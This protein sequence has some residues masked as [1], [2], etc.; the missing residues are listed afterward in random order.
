MIHTLRYVIAE[1][2]DPYQNIADEA[3]LLE[4]VKEGE[5]ILFL[6]Q[7]QHTVV[8]GRNQNAWVECAVER[9][10]A[11]GGH[12]TRR[13]SGGGAVYH[14][15]GNINFTY[16]LRQ[17]DY[18]LTRQ[19]RVIANAMRS[20]GLEIEQSGR[21]DL[22]VDGR[23][24]SGHAYYQHEGR[25]Y[26]HGTLLFNVDTEAMAKYLRVSKNK[27]ASKGVQSVRSRVAN[28]I[29]FIPEI[30][31]EEIYRVFL[32]AFEKEYGG[33]ATRKELS[34]LG[35]DRRKE[36]RSFFASPEWLYGPK[37]PLNTERSERFP[38]GEVRLELDVDEGKVKAL[39][40]YSDAMNWAWV[41]ALEEYLLG[42]PFRQETIA[43]A[44][45]SFAQM[46]EDFQ[47]PMKE[48]MKT[49]FYH[50]FD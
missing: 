35:E 17:E 27:M 43:E 16:L 38:W 32:D 49:L 41:K 21:N 15:L 19:N 29:E 28:L 4:D 31:K 30:S 47:D 5:I 18:D 34:S 36:K 1:D 11:D 44:L 33:S 24:F 9:L 2:T 20:L 26:H 39:R 22:L 48:D 45:E 3:L 46:Q 6:W 25:S 13:L 12:L 7:N 42:Q 50:I 8:I 37:I 14:D 40:L 23:K 10:E